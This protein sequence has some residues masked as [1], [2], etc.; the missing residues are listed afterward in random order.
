[1]DISSFQ[2]N[3]RTGY[4]EQHLIPFIF[5]VFQ[6]FSGVKQATINEQFLWKYD[7]NLD[8]HLSWM[9]M[10]FVSQINRYIS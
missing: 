6:S 8:M 1:M 7:I 3:I 5:F 2:C 10:K 4:Y 9:L